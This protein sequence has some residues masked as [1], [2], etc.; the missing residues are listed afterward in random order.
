VISLGLNRI[1]IQKASGADLITHLPTTSSAG[2]FGSWLN[3]IGEWFSGSWQRHLPFPTADVM[4]FGAVWAC[5]TLVAS[6]IAKLWINLMEEVAGVSTPVDRSAYL[7]V[8]K[9]PNHYQTRVKFIE[10]W[11][12]SRLTNGNTYVL[13]ERDNRGV[14]SALYILDPARVQVLVAPNGDV[15]YQC[16][17]D[18]LAGI[19]AAS[20]TVP[21][22][23]II[24]D[25]CVPLYHPLCGVS[26]IHAAGMA[27]MQGLQIQHQSAKTFSKG[28]NLSGVL[29]AP[30]L[31]TQ[32]TAERIAKSWQQNFTG[33]QALGKVAVLGDGL[34]FEKMSMTAV[35]A[36]LIE[37]L[38][39]TAEDVARCYHVPGYMIGIGPAPP[40]TDIQSINLQYYT[41]ALQNAIENHEIL[42][43]EGLELRPGLHVEFDLDALARMD[44]KTQMAIAKDGV[45][46]GI[47]TINEERAGFNRRPVEGGEAPLLQQQNWPLAQLA[48]RPIDPPAP[49][50]AKPEPPAPEPAERSI[51]VRILT[52][53]AAECARKAMAA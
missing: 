3:T 50:P 9:K 41:Q 43:D 4:T 46:A 34:K 19:E 38:K 10:Q 39:W 40:Y 35:D 12:I 24:H 36:Q 31:I 44:K 48:T 26:P 11:H 49:Q 27:A 15:F 32:P 13:K 25:V 18:R 45:G 51:D 5:V 22:S 23:E 14:V 1:P 29:T 37:Q 20:I 28:L 30:G 53:A 47:F 33:P 2:W 17:T 42:F 7:P 16:S 8:L 6:D 52:L 21:A